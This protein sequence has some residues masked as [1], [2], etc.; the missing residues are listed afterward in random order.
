LGRHDRRDARCNSRDFPTFHNCRVF[1]I[2]TG[3]SGTRFWHRACCRPAHGRYRYR[4]IVQSR[5]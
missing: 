1:W 2:A 3:F 5:E 4:S